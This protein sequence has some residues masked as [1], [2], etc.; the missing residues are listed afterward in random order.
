MI[1][2][3]KV[4]QIRENLNLS[5]KEFADRL[6]VTQ[7]MV[8]QLEAS[9]RPVPEDMIKSIQGLLQSGDEYETLQ[10]KV[11]LLSPGQVQILHQVLDEFLG[12]ND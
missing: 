4:R 3:L 8:S 1:T 6:Q 5:Q 2:N 12:F 10:R 11:K 9:K 7:S